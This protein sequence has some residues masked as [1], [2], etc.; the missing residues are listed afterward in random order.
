MITDRDNQNSSLVNLYSPMYFENFDAAMNRIDAYC[1]SIGFGY[2]I[3]NTRAPYGVIINRTI[4]CYCH[5]KYIEQK[6]E[7]LDR[8]MHIG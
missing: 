5:G 6:H 2:V 3:E 1:K 7:N 8:S 4:V